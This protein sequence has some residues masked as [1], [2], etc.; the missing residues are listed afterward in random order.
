[1]PVE[2][3]ARIVHGALAD[4][5]ARDTDGARAAEAALEWMAGWEGD[6]A[7]LVLRRYDLQV[8][9]WYALPRRWVVPADD[10]ERIALSMARLLDGLGDAA[11]AY[12]A[13]C[14][15]HETRRLLRAWGAGDPAAP[16]MLEAALETS[17]LEPPDTGLLRWGSLMGPQEAGVRHEV[18]ALLEET[19]EAGRL[20]PGARGFAAARSREVE[21]FLR[22]PNARLDGRA[23]VDVVGDER[24]EL[25]TEQ[26]SVER[27][28]I[29]ASAASL[30][31]LRR[32]S[33]PRA[34]PWSRSPGC[35]TPPPTTGWRSPRPARSTA[36]SCEAPSS[37]SRP[38]GAA[39][40]S[41]HPTVSTRSSRCTRSTACCA[42]RACCVAPSSAL[43]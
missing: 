19:V 20:V 42:A 28:A 8:F 37:A 21:A 6:G 12:A 5:S 39:T 3:P 4:L 16:R 36:R 15:G 10:H 40:S 24:L 32:P 1:M 25:W 13:L 22:A 18:T 41:A 30:L 26:G 23:L 29:L 9:L 31:R 17:G 27:R 14:R 34:A 43:A 7:P 35:W 11:C 2:V 38:G 33:S